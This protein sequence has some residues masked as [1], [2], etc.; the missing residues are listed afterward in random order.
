[1]I[2]RERGS[3]SSVAMTSAL[4]PIVAQNAGQSLKMGFEFER[5]RYAEAVL[6]K[7]GDAGIVAT[8]RA[9]VTPGH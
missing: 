2:A 7:V 4:L 6:G 5:C 9:R 8:G 3:V 1:M